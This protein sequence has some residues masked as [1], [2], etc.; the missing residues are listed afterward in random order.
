MPHYKA[1]IFDLDGTLLDTLDDLADAVNAALLHFD[2]PLRT[3]EEVRRFV[4]NG[5]RLLIL[6]ALPVG[7]EEARIN[8]VLAYFKEYYAAHSQEKTAPYRGARELLAVLKAA[9]VRVCIVSNKFDAAVQELCPFYFGDAVLYAAGERAGIPKKPAPDSVYAAMDAVGV[10]AEEA[11]YIGDSEVDVETARNAGVDAISVLW[12]F[13][14]RDCLAAH[15]AA[16]FAESMEEL[17]RIL[18]AD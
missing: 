2:Y 7:V 17:S 15:G 6:R 10:T 11:V 4:G 14:D 12:G 5:V 16:L 8:E 18:L 13:R 1:A 9:G 3:R